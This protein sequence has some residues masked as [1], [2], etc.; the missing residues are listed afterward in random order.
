MQYL[1][2][3]QK[4]ITHSRQQHHGHEE[5]DDAFDR[6]GG[7]SALYWSCGLLVLSRDTEV[8]LQA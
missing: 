2:L 8:S 5:R 3:C 7:A 1:I 6:H 4:C